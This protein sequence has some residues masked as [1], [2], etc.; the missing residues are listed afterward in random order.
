MTSLSSINS[1]PALGAQRQAIASSPSTAK[2]TA[3]AATAPASIVT[4]SQSGAAASAQDG[5]GMLEAAKQLVWE[6]KSSDALSYLMAYNYTFQPSAGRFAGIGAAMLDQFKSGV[7]QISQT[8]QQGSPATQLNPYGGVVLDTPA[9]LHGLGDNQMTLNITTKSGVKVSLSLDSREDGI[10]VQMKSDGEL[11]DAERGALA[12][13]A[14]GFQDAIDGISSGQPKIALDGL[15]QFDPSVL[16][17][18][19]FHASIQQGAN[20]SQSLDF[21]ADAAKRTMSLNGPAGQAQVSVDLSSPLGRGSPAQQSKAIANYLKQFDQA[22]S[23]GKADAS[24]MAM[25][26]D[27]FTEMNSSYGASAQAQAGAL[28]SISLEDQDY[29]MLTGLA[30]FSASVTQAKTSPNPM[31]PSEKD[32]FS[33]QLSQHTEIKGPDQADRSISQTQQSSLQASYHQPPSPNVR[34]VLTTAAESQNYS[35]YTIND[36][37]SSSVDMA[38]QKGILVKANLTQSASQ[39]TRIQKYVHGHL[40]DDTTTPSQTTLT[41]DLVKTLMPDTKKDETRTPLE[42]YQRQQMLSATNDM[43]FLQ[44]DPARLQD[45]KQDLMKTVLIRK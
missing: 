19:D 45:E 1:S 13:L 30:D 9:P 18:V 35:Y 17:S 27:A 36:T 3:T 8:V 24:L 38:Y 43:I 28:P 29:S 23:R 31:R 14:Q 44:T 6:S 4:L 26:K 37:A 21:H 40:T 5:A 32:S 25:F 33:Y 12:K 41:Q 42:R 2:S 7:T 10:A 34:L 22:G 16:A 20:A 15:T 39:S 11:S